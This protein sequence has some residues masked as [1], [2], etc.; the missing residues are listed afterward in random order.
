MA[1]TVQQLRD[2]LDELVQQGNGDMEIKFS[3][4]YGDYWRTTVAEDINNVSEVSVKYSD[5]HSMDKV[6]DLS[7]E[8][9]PEDPKY[10]TILIL[11]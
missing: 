7:E 11:E 9:E 10:R 8:D 5:Y 3:Y 4:N 2:T 6:V 1:M